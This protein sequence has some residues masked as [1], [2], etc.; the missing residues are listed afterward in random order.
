M[1]LKTQDQ[2]GLLN[3][4]MVFATLNRLIQLNKLKASRITGTE[5]QN[6]LKLFV[7]YILQIILEYFVIRSQQSETE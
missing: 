2:A 5:P 3:L 6:T 7:R 1:D 4:K